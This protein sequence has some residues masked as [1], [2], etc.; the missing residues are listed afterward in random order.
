VAG[1]VRRAEWVRRRSPETASVLA[2]LVERDL[3]FDDAGMLW[4]GPDGE[5]SFGAKNF[6]ELTS[7][8]T[9]D[10]MRR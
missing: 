1:V 2:D 9:A 6:L 4:V 10:P 7:V 3:L 5:R 8:F